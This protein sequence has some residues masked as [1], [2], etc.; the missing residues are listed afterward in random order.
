MH[1][2]QVAGIIR[3]KSRNSGF[4]GKLGSQVG[5]EVSCC[6]SSSSSSRGGSTESHGAEIGSKTEEIWSR[7]VNVEI[8]ADKTLDPGATKEH[9][10]ARVID[11]RKT[12]FLEV[13]PYFSD[14]WIFF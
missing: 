11:L 1:Q 10:I 13:E 6:C 12:D 8:N 14:H 7:K 9:G 3:S 2:M 4:P 5:S